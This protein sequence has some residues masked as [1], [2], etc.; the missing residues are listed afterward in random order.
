LRREGASEKHSNMLQAFCV[1][2]FCFSYDGLW[3]SC[4][5]LHQS[6]IVVGFAAHASDGWFVGGLSVP[7]LNCKAR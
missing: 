3:R 2:C 4:H 5:Q 1:L 6:D 7:C